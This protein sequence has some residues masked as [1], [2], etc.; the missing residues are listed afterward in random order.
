MSKYTV[1]EEL[2][3]AFEADPRSLREIGRQTGISAAKLTLWRQ[4]KRGLRLRDAQ[5]MAAVLG[6]QLQLVAAG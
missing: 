1:E 6:L 5:R 3:V 2:R 4:C